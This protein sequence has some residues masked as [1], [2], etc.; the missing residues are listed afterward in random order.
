M[1]KLVPLFLLTGVMIACTDRKEVPKDILKKEKMQEVMWDMVSAGEFLN[2]YILNKDSVDRFSESAK[3][4]AQVLQ[5]HQVTR[6]QFEKSYLYYRQH[7][8]LMK[9]IMDS[10]ATR[11]VQPDE[12]YKPKEDSVK[13]DTAI[14]LADTIAR[15]ADADSARRRIPKKVPLN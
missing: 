12:I 7:P 2:G 11:Q 15:A 8:D 3:V 13:A 14:K 1:R 4:Y 5:F 10:L 6:E 9:V